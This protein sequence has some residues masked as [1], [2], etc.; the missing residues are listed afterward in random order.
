ML[1]D[2]ELRATA[3][4]ADGRLPLGAPA[5]RAA[6]VRP[7]AAP[8]GAGANV[9]AWF[10]AAGAALVTATSRR[11][12]YDAAL[13]AA[14]AADAGRAEITLYELSDEALSPVAGLRVPAR[15]RRATSPGSATETL[16]APERGG[17][18]SR[19][20]A[21]ILLPLAARGALLGLLEIAG[22]ALEGQERILLVALAQQISLALESAALTEDL[23]RG[24][25]R[26]APRVARALSV[27]A[28]PRRLGRTPRSATRA[29]PSSA[30]S[31]ARRRR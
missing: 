20:R 29:R 8:P 2:L 27:R 15:P 14:E 25:E 28:R 12:I 1:L 10:A 13:G 6:D 22:P 3:R 31:G 7:G 18:R 11:E 26:G 19:A 17:R 9:P 21:G 4:A 5:G 30:C 24:R 23:H 16:Q